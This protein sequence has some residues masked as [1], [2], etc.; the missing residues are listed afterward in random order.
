MNG[1]E[2]PAVP[3]EVTPGD[4]VM[5]NHQIKH[6]SWGGGDRRRMFTLNFEERF[7]DEDVETLKE[8]MASET[9]F[10]I[11]RNYGDVM[12]NTADRTA[13]CTSNSAWRTTATWP[14]SPARPAPKWPSRAE[15]R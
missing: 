1:D 4:L 9:R 7:A 6:S 12:V 13:W 10:W 15:G 5:F 3:L 2:V 8:R 11:E 14:S